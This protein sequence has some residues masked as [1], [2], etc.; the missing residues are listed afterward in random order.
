MGSSVEP[1]ARVACRPEALNHLQEFPK[2]NSRRRALFFLRRRTS[3]CVFHPLQTYPK[4]KT[5]T[6]QPSLANPSTATSN[7]H[8]R[9]FFLIPMKDPPK[10][11]IYEPKPTH[12]RRKTSVGVVVVV[13]SSSGALTPPSVWLYRSSLAHCLRLFVGV[14]CVCAY[15]CVLCV[16]CVGCVRRRRNEAQHYFAFLRPPSV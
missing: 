16:L 6:F 2:L 14:C 3:W 13:A 5:R 9:S 8:F 10:I 11:Y 12:K 15:V 4:K 7:L 1:N